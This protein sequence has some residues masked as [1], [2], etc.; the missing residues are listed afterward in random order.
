MKIGIEINGVLRDTIGK[1]EQV[2]R[3]NFLDVYEEEMPSKTY[4]LDYSGNTNLIDATEP[5]KFEIIEPINSLNLLQHFKFQ[6]KDDLY[7]FLYEEFPMEIFGHA[8]SSETMT[9]NDLNE[10]YIEHRDNHDIL[11]VSDEMSKSKPSSLFFLSKFG[12][13]IEKIKFYSTIT[14]DSMWDEVDLLVTSNPELIENH[15]NG[16]IVIK[17][18]TRYNEHVKCNLEIESIKELKTKLKEI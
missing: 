16:K 6:T 8:G 15:P 7:T 9:F 2:Y 1:I 18:K 14:L 11:I 5:F 17:Y 3:K 4:E 13:L 12:C 10:F